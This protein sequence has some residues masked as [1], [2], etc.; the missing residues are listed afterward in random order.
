[1][2]RH[3]QV[4]MEDVWKAIADGTNFRPRSIVARVALWFGCEL[5]AVDQDTGKVWSVREV[6][7][8]TRID[9]TGRYDE[10]VLVSMF[11]PISVFDHDLGR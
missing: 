1:M 2:N 4:P 7:G 5:W 8:L 11:G 6:D 3:L 9:F 10:N